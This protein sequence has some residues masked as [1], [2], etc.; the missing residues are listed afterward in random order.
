MRRTNIAAL[1]LLLT[2]ASCASAPQSPGAAFATEILDTLYL[3]TG[4]P[5][6][7]PP[8]SDS[9]WRAFLAEVVTA[10]FPDG[11]TAWNA[12]GQW[13]QS[14]RAEI[15]SEDSHVLQLIHEDSPLA[16]MAIDEIIAAYK[17]RFAQQSVL[18]VRTVVR[19]TWK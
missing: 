14:G 13:R 10:H 6:P 5:A 7:Q 12:Y 4:R 17:S 18:R 1:I 19:V 3:G 2:L 16:D 8:V 11:L 15:V 9:E